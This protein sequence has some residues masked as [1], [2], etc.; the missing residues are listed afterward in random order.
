MQLTLIG[1]TMGMEESKEDCVKDYHPIFSQWR[2]Q[3]FIYTYL[4]GDIVESKR[5]CQGEAVSY[6]LYA[7]D[8]MVFVRAN[9]KPAKNKPISYLD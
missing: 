7:D 5:S 3:G 6:L 8:L 4:S 9:T 2:F 1:L